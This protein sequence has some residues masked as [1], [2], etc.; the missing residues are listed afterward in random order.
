MACMA[1]E[2]KPAP[3]A[4]HD[5]IVKLEQGLADAWFTIR[6]MQQ[7]GGFA[8]SKMLSTRAKRIEDRVER[9]EH[10]GAMHKDV[11]AHAVDLLGSHLTGRHGVD[12]KDNSPDMI[13]LRKIKRRLAEWAD[14]VAQMNK[15][16]VSAR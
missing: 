8:D 15:R 4:D 13:F 2:K 12:E 10:D 3:P 16:R 5:R 7:I 6:Q 9:L 1:D 14:A 11:T